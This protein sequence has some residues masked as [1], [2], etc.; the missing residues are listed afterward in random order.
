MQQRT[1]SLQE[2]ETRKDDIIFPQV[3]HHI[4]GETIFSCI[5]SDTAV[6]FP[7]NVLVLCQ[8][9]SGNFVILSFST[10]NSDPI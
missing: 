5:V 8:L 4:Y 3:Q 9:L 2:V 1:F 6:K 10:K 7:F